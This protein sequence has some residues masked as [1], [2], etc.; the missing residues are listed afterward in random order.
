MVAAVDEW[1]NTQER[2]RSVMNV[3]GRSGTY[4]GDY[5]DSLRRLGYVRWR[6]GKGPMRKQRETEGYFGRNFWKRFSL[7]DFANLVFLLREYPCLTVKEIKQLFLLQLLAFWLCFCLFFPAI[8]DILLSPLVSFFYFPSLIN[9]R[10]NY[11]AIKLL[12]CGV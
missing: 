3:F 12:L 7:N 4:L 10:G 2:I 9:F 6:L 8:E 5:R 11:S 1:V